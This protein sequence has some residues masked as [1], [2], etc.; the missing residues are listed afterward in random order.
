MAVG[1]SIDDANELCDLP[2]FQGRIG[3][4]AINS[5][6]SVTLSGDLDAIE[7][8]KEILDDEKKFARLLKVDKAYHSHHMIP[9]SDAYRKSLADCEIKVLRPARNSPTWLS[10]VYGEDITNYRRDLA[11]EY[12]ISNMANPVLFLQAIE[13]AAAEEGPFD[14]AIEVGPHPALKGPALQVLQEFL[15]E[16]IPYTGVLSRGKDDK[17]AF[18][19]GLGY[20]WQ[21][22]GLDAIDYKAFD[23]FLVGPESPSPRILPNLPPYAWDHDRKFW[24]E[25]R[26]YAVNRTKPDPPHEILGTMC[27]DGWNSNIG[28]GTSSDHRKF[29]GFLAT[30]SRVRWC[31]PQPATF[32]PR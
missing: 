11:S 23:Q 13:F 17:E 12:W 21:V 5:R 29:P 3:V 8:A 28:G 2:E 14:A 6:A 22:F 9:C 27:P 4:A 20:L 26:Q 10:S 30:R 15:G 1:T 31:S 7:A 25:S 16:S 18:A 32:L 24:H 19:E